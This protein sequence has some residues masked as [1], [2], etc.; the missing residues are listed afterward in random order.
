MCRDKSNPRR[1]W[2][3]KTGGF[4]PYFYVFGDSTRSDAAEIRRMYRD[5]KYLVSLVGEPVTKIETFTPPQVRDLRTSVFRHIQTY[6]S[7]VLFPNNYLATTGIKS[8]I[9]IPS[10]VLDSSMYSGES[11]SFDYF[12][13]DYSTIKPS[14]D[15]YIEPLTT[16]LDIEVNNSQGGLP[17]FRRPEMPI[18]MNS[19]IDTYTNKM[20]TF[21]WHPRRTY[22]EVRQEI[23]HFKK[24][25]I[26]VPWKIFLFTEELTMLEH[27]VEYLSKVKQDIITG[28][29]IQFD[30]SY[31][32]ARCEKLG[33]D[34]SRISPINKVFISRY[35]DA[36]IG[37][38]AI[39][40]M[41][42]CYK[43][44]TKFTGMKDSYKLGD[45]GFDELA[46]PKMP[47]QGSVG[48]FW[49]QKFKASIMYNVRDEIGRAS[50]RER[51]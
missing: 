44:L 26:D 28:W 47:H 17:S 50:C 29:N 15:I 12:I 30:L 3:I 27:I 22:D 10:S 18:T 5:E 32:I 46:L 24:S 7:K 33:I 13:R 6:Q 8:G 43:S 36:T 38:V 37:C 39:M 40:D 20:Y 23:Y 14:N 11:D 41:L 9:S 48:Q 2:H 19:S 45:V 21:A 35:G 16:M 1:Q 31:I 25:N 34:V 4:I 51:V 42:E 49:L